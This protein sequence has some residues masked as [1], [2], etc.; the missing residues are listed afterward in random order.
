M[1]FQNSVIFQQWL[2]FS[3]SCGNM[4]QSIRTNNSMYSERANFEHHVFL[5]LLGVLECWLQLKRSQVQ[6]PGSGMDIRSQSAS[7]L[8]RGPGLTISCLQRLTLNTLRCNILPVYCSRYYQ[9]SYQ[10]FAR[11]CFNILP[12]LCATFCQVMVQHFTCSWFNLKTLMAQP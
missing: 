2:N 8:N 12:L 4:Q 11:S 9:S 6:N 1:I 10:N 7:T 3:P 5:L